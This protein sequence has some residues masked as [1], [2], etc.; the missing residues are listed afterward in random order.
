[1]FRWRQIGDFWGRVIF[2][3]SPRFFKLG[4]V[5]VYKVF[6]K[7]VIPAQSSFYS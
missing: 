3:I 6:D 7:A 5:L 4:A 2:R 1:M